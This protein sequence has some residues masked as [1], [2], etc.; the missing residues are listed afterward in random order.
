M[1][2]SLLL[3]G[4]LMG[5]VVAV[6]VG[7]LGLLCINRALAL[8]PT[9]G[10]FSGLGVA[11]ADSLAAAIAALGIT[12]I[13]GFLS[14]HQ[15]TL[16][17]IGGA[18]LCYLGYT[19]YMTEPVTQAPIKSINGLFGAY[20][21]TFILT[22]S[23]PITIL[24]FVAIYAGWH[25]PSLDGQYMAAATLTI[26]VFVGSA[27][28][29]VALFIGLEAFHE[30]FNLRFLFWVHRVTGG[31]IAVFGVVILFSLTPWGQSLGG[32]F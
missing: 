12:L 28:W 20:A 5:L 26:G 9:Y 29:W 27:L 6:P 4:I 23:N 22:F 10:L 3:Q 17:L 15:L 8:G 21:T 16:R 11:T 2:F 25:V 1:S 19:I 18:F 31:I 14:D 32:K 13:S 7:P 30:K 24:S